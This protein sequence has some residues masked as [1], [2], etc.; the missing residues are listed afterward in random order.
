MKAER[1]PAD[2]LITVQDFG[3][4]G[5]KE[6]LTTATREGYPTMWQTFSAAARQAIEEGRQPNGKVLWLLADICSMMLSPKSLNEPFKPIMVMDGQRS[7]IPDDLTDADIAFFAQTVDEVGDCWL[8]ARLADVVWLKGKPRN[9]KFAL[10]AIDAYRSISLDT[11]T[12]VRDGRECWERALCLTCSLGGGAG[13]RLREMDSAIVAAFN[14]ARRED[15]FLALWLADLLATYGLG[16]ENPTA[17]A[18]KLESLARTFDGEGDRHRAREYFRAASDRFK[19]AGDDAKSAEMTVAQAECWVKEAL[20][21]LS[22]QNPSHIAAASFY[23]NA[24][25]TY[26]T[27]PRSE[28]AIHRVDERIAPC[29][30]GRLGPGR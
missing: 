12:W 9:M 11:E 29:G 23:E 6:A 21:R 22:S 13:D 25:Q 16:G 24:I 1:Y 3:T 26:R 27:I 10:A 5:W 28:R 4:C 19:K 8:K 18:Q 30:C 14:A 7:I 17:I 2:L 20:A 15:G